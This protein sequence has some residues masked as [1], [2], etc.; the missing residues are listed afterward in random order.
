MKQPSAET[1]EKIIRFF[2]ETS[3]PRILAKKQKEKEVNQHAKTPQ[4]V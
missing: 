2:L 1:R 4:R 3:V